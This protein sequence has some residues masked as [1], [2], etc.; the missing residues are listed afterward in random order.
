MSAVLVLSA[1]TL[2]SD[3]K[4]YTGTISGGAGSGY[5]PSS[6]VTGIS[7][8]GGGATQTAATA[9]ISGSTLTFTTTNIFS[10]D[11]TIKFAISSGSNLTDGTNGAQGQ[12]NV[13]VDN[14]ANTQPQF[15]FRLGW[16]RNG[17]HKTILVYFTKTVSDGYL[18]SNTTGWTVTVNGVSKSFTASSGSPTSGDASS[19]NV[20]TLTGAAPAGATVVVA[21]DASIGDAIQNDRVVLESF[22][23][24]AL[25]TSFPIDAVGVTLLGALE[26]PTSAGIHQY[27]V[28]TQLWLT[29]TGTDLQICQQAWGTSWLDTIDGTDGSF[30]VGSS[31]AGATITQSVFSSLSDT[32]HTVRLLNPQGNQYL[33]RDD[34]FLV[35]G[36]NP[37]ISAHLTAP[38]PINLYAPPSY[39]R[40]DGSWFPVNNS[41]VLILASIGIM[42]EVQFRAKISELRVYSPLGNINAAFILVIDGAYQPYSSQVFPMVPRTG[43]NILTLATGLDNTTYHDYIIQSVHTATYLTQ[44]LIDPTDVIDTTP[45]PARKRIMVSGDSISMGVGSSG[46]NDPRLLWAWRFAQHLGLSLALDGESGRTLHGNTNPLITGGGQTLPPNIIDYFFQELGTNEA[47]A[48]ASKTTF[49]A[50]EADCISNMLPYLTSTGIYYSMDIFPADNWFSTTTGFTRADYNAAKRAA[51]T[52]AANPKVISVETDSAVDP[53]HAQPHPDD[54]GVDQVASWAI[55]LRSNPAYTVPGPSSGTVGVDSAPFTV[56]PANSNVFN[57]LQSITITPPNGTVTIT[58]AGGT[59]SGNTVTP[60]KDAASFTYT[61]TR[62]SAGSA[63]DTVSNGQGWTNPS[64]ASFNATSAGGGEGGLVSPGFIGIGIGI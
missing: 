29:V 46:G 51:V 61:V 4:T 53:F 48:S 50:D 49:T 14:S 12:T 36:S 47:F 13:A 25:P 38:I 44:L 9:T 6:G 57:G 60:P 64:P 58:S 43:D 27:S 42:G 10:L 55:A 26:N 11:M 30:S 62:S 34:F 59:V 19:A 17:D 20:M 35:S 7:V 41:G 5:G 15:S 22:T 52:A 1:I 24:P 31:P 23:S 18:G 33:N 45:I 37:S 21:Y 3:G 63:G 28:Q 2:A 32:G 40:V 56:T 39:V 8:T 54:Y 16:I